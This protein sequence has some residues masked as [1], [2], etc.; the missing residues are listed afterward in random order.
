MTDGV[1]TLLAPGDTS[2]LKKRGL[3]HAVE[4]EFN[5]ASIYIHGLFIAG[6]GRLG[7]ITM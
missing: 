2:P 4:T 3:F 6:K 5:I 7:I 1:R